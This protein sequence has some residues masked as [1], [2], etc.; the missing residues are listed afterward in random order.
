MKEEWR[1]LLEA[2]CFG[3][4]I[5]LYSPLVQWNSIP[6]LSPLHYLRRRVGIAFSWACRED[7]ILQI[8]KQE[9]CRRSPHSFLLHWWT[10]GT[11][12]KHPPSMK[13]D[14]RLLLEAT[15]LGICIVLYSQLAQWNSISSLLC[16]QWQ[17]VGIAFSWPCG[18][19]HRL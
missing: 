8:P 16:W 12:K 6:T 1:L 19:D 5:V 3:I 13:E 18:E 15:C 11:C 17:R 9:A 10:Q 4:C 2:T 7:H 14:W